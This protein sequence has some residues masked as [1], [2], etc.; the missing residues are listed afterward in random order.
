LSDVQ[1]LHI[2]TLLGSVRKGSLNAAVVRALPELAPAGMT[3]TALPSVGDYPIYDADLQAEGF[4]AVVEEAAAA[5][6]TADGVVIVSPE[7]NYSI[8]GGLKNALDWI[9]RLKGQPFAGKPVAIQSVS[10]GLLGGTRMQYH[11]RQSLVFLDAHVLNKPEVM[12]GQG[13]TKIDAA[14]GKLTDETTRKFVADQLTAFAAYIAR[15]R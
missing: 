11:L 15:L 7:Y 14:T 9:S 5:I 10:A 12:I 3:F 2:V 8:P 4:P 6:R 1:P 13:Q